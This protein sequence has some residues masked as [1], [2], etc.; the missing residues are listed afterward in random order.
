MIGDEKTAKEAFGTIGAFLSHVTALVEASKKLKPHDIALIME[1]DVSIP[2]DW[3]KQLQSVVD[4]APS[5]WDLIKLSGFG[6]HRLADLVNI[7]EVNSSQKENL[8]VP[9]LTGNLAGALGT[10]AK[11]A[12]PT[13]ATDAL[14]KS[15][16]DSTSP[17][18]YWMMNGP[19]KEPAF[20]SLGTQGPGSPNIFYGGAGAYVV[21]G[22][23]IHKVINRL[24]SKPIDDV[25]SMMLI[26]GTTDNSTTHSYDIWPHIF[27]LAAIAMHGPGLHTRF[28]HDEGNAAVDHA[29]SEG[30]MRPGVRGK[31]HAFLGPP[32][33]ESEEIHGQVKR[34][35]F[36]SP[37][38]I[39]L[40]L[41][42]GGVIVMTLAIICSIQ[43]CIRRGRA[44]QPK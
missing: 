32:L 19:F 24:R 18:T 27:E 34:Y 23:Y 29:E 38:S 6:A 1:D 35:P 14:M 33:H 42:V 8:P 36:D 39:R 3:K 7:S 21:R 30:Q 37:S 12:L 22:L 26:D 28:A 43:V 5:D 9:S 17:T 15:Q 40:V 10:A 13:W 25:D 4:K 44:R 16:T 41:Y 20:M 11:I 31:S 2:E